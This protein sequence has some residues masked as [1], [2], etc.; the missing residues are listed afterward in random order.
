MKKFI[1]KKGRHYSTF[2]RKLFNLEFGFITKN[3]YSFV[4]KFTESCLYD[5]NDIPD[6]KD[7]NKLCGISTSYNHHIQ[8]ARFGWRCLD[9]KHIE[10][11]TYCYDNKKLLKFDILGTVLPEEIF[12][13]KIIVKS[14]RFVFY[15]K[16]EKYTKIIEVK[17]TL[18]S[19]YFKYK[20]GFY[21][22]GNLKAPHDMT[23]YLRD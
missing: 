18:K 8:S 14:D 4:A 22:G 16:K 19:S 7:I 3:T 6:E 15:F 12:S 13:G 23:L 2:L 1:I 11:L 10:I 17:K 5:F 21:F 9:N 20:L